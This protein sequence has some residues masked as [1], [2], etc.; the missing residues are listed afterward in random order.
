[1]I[2]ARFQ[3]TYLYFRTFVEGIGYSVLVY[4]LAQNNNP[5]NRDEQLNL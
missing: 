1:M 4:L 2:T 3:L 5:C